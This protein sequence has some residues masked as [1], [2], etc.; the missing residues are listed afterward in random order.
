[1]QYLM[2]ISPFGVYG[3]SSAGSNCDTVDGASSSER[4]ASERIRAKKT[5][6]AL[7]LFL[8]TF[9]LVWRPV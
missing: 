3:I 8:P 9:A 1:M 5:R 6:A 2:V 4:R 7:L